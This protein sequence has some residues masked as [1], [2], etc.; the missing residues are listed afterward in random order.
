MNYVDISSWQYG[1]SLDTLFGANPSLDGVIV[2]SSGGVSYVQTTC[3]AWVQW[4]I[5][6]RKPWGFY[7]YLD[8]D[9]RKSSGAEEARFFVSQTRNYF[10]LGLPF[11]DYEADAKQM[12]TGYLKE[13]LD[14]VYELTGVKA[15][16]YCSLSVVQSQDFSA[17]AAAGYPLWVAQY[18]D[19]NPV[20]GFVDNPWQ[21]GSYAPFARYIAHQYTSRG[22]LNGWGGNL[23]FDKVTVTA[24]EWEAL[25]AG[26]EEPQPG[27][28]AELKGPDP[29]V[30][31]D[32]LDGRYGIGEERVR[33]LREAGY[34]PDK[35]QAKIN[36]LYGIAAKIRPLIEG[37][38]SYLDSIIRIVRT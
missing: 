8:D 5:K 17:I 36:E 19:Y 25:A 13:F 14:T 23:D 12:G 9:G 32:L 37:N 6:N 26:R 38:L 33:K 24:E 2:K 27:P 3:D 4:L 1:L 22:R 28:P 31:S 29:A 11:A 30:V 7:H 21:K 20:Y 18:P 34:D 15:G 10:G 35:V 16:V